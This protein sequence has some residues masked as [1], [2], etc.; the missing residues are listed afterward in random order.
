MSQNLLSAAA[1]VIG[2]LRVKIHSF[3]ITPNKEARDSNYYSCRKDTV[4]T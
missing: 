4:L 1:V 3:V 2:P